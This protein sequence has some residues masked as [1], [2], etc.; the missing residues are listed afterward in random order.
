MKTRAR[1]LSTIALSAVLLAGGAVTTT[2]S[3]SAAG[4]CSTDRFCAFDG[5]NFAGEKL[6]NSATQA[7]TTVTVTGDR[8][9]SV[10][11]KQD[12]KWCGVAGQAIGSTI[13]T[14]IADNTSLSDLSPHNDEIDWFWAGTAGGC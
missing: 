11:N 10:I 12:R 14:R 1:L 6:L 8:V 3:A 9:A 13:V 2:V 4:T 7:N 5:R